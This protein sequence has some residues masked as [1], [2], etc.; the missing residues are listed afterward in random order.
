MAD[1]K[2]FPQQITAGA[3]GQRHT[4]L[5]QAMGMADM[6]I[7]TYQKVRIRPEDKDDIRDGLAGVLAFVGGLANSLG[8]DL[9]DLFDRSLKMVTDIEEADMAEQV[10]REQE[11][12]V[13]GV[14]LEEALQALTALLDNLGEDDIDWEDEEE[15]PDEVTA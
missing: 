13:D 14:A 11:G 5:A 1:L 3:N 4:A 2:T 9:E 8:F 15:T 10:A 7:A 12:A 6:A